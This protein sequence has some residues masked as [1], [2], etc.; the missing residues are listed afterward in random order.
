M[1]S[2]D[3]SSRPDPAAAWVVAP[4]ASDDLARAAQ[5]VRLAF[6]TQAG[7]PAPGEFWNDRDYVRGRWHAPH[8]AWFKAS[9]G[10]RIAG[11]ACVTRRGSTGIV[12]PVAVHPDDWNRRVAR[13]LMRAVLER[14]D[15]W[16]VRHAGLFTFPNSAKHLAL[17]QGFGFWPRTLTLV[18]A[19]APRRA[20]MADAVVRYGSEHGARERLKAECA[21][22]TNA[23]APG[24]EVSGDL[25]AVFD[26]ELGATLVLPDAAG[27]AAFAVCHFGPRS[28]AGADVLYIR[29]AAVRPGAACAR[30]FE[31]LIAACEALAL[32]EGLSKVMAGVNTAR[33]QACRS[34]WSQ[35]FKI[36]LSGITM[37]R[38]GPGYDRPEVH[39]LDDWR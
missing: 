8:T 26:Q 27:A 30:D 3:V 18:M 16:G 39:I 19:R 22:I 28:E 4:L 21:A 1:H 36:E 14:L 5:V 12:G 7:A 20:R 15:V 37:H 23:I 17:Y 32:A 2:T 29:F 13:R 11:V 33:E 38:G 24:L 34:L 10:E 9:E 25:D 35:G 6:A 31:R